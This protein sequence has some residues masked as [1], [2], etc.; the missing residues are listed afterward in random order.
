MS[1]AL[2]G[3]A[4]VSPGPAGLLAVAICVVGVFAVALFPGP[5]TLN[6]DTSWLIELCERILS[7]ERL[8]EDVLETNP[9]MSMLLYLGP[10]ALARSFG[11]SPE[12]MVW[13]S[14]WLFLAASL[15][16]CAAIA[17]RAAWF[18]GRG[19][20]VFLG[21][22]FV[23]FGLMP[24]GVFTQREH[25][26]AM[27]YA[28]ALLLLLAREQAGFRAPAWL[29]LACGVGMGL[30]VAI[31]PHFALACVA[32]A[33]VV[34]IRRR[35][36]LP[37]FRPENLIGA[38]VFGAYAALVVT[39]FPDFFRTTFP[40]VAS[41]YA[42]DVD[43]LWKFMLYPASI[44]MMV[45]L[46]ATLVILR[47]A[48][49]GTGPW[50]AVVAAGAFIIAYLLQSKGWPYH[51]YPAVTALCLAVVLA[52]LGKGANGAALGARAAGRLASIAMLC[53]SVVFAVGFRSQ[54]DMGRLKA[55][56]EGRP[57]GTSLLVVSGDIAIGFPLAR[58]LDLVWYTRG[59]AQ[60]LAASALRRMG[61]GGVD[62]AERAHLQHAIETDRR[63]LV[64]DTARRR[65]DVL[66]F[67]VE[68]F[69]WQAWA[70][71]DPAFFRMMREY[72]LETIVEG[73]RQGV[74]KVYARRG[75]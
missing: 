36:L 52:V 27:A 72:R 28:P 70:M 60:W 63:W 73:E 54:L 19:A 18:D 12:A 40:W 31:K 1:V 11:V 2:P 48:K 75:D 66:V 20:A 30:V 7:G 26:A 33:A 56:L 24:T 35:N 37:L 34:A 61:R 47:V 44:A 46:A 57:A 13:L 50:I 68:R 16:L 32:P 51:V 17:R 49:A 8:Y 29:V 10:V 59:N 15:A 53:V 43:P 55:A 3:R 39:V 64:E 25:F 67:E 62:E 21:A 6:P 71:A 23:L 14:T 69:D 4:V 38:A 5:L 45:M 58:E 42:R 41:V 74:Y 22:L 9:P 65:P